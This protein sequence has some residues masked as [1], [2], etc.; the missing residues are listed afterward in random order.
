MFVAFL[1]FSAFVLF[2][3][4]NAHRKTPSNYQV[5][6]LTF[7]YSLPF[8]AIRSTVECLVVELF[9]VVFF[10]VYILLFF[11]CR[12]S[13]LKWICSFF[14]EFETNFVTETIC[15]KYC[16]TNLEQYGILFLP[17]VDLATA[18]ADAEIKDHTVDSV[19]AK[20]INQ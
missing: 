4:K 1:F 6:K 13:K 5:N 11:F 15:K 16:D 9:V 2:R 14:I 8:F 18:I 7:F 19:P 20:L 17:N 10:F 3:K 12:N